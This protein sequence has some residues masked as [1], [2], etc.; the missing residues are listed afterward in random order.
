MQ[1]GD[2]VLITNTA[3]VILFVNPAFEQITGHAAADVLGRT[4][5]FLNAGVHHKFFFDT[6]WRVI[7]G[8][9]VFRGVISNRHK[10]G[11]VYQH[12][13]TITAI[14]DEADEI[15]HFLS[16]GRDV[17]ERQL[18]ATRFE[19]LA[20][21]DLLTGL[22]NRGLFMDRLAQAMLRCQREPSNLALLFID[23]DRFKRI[24]DSHGHSVGDEVLVEVARRLRSA[25]RNEDSVARLGGDEFTI[26]I[27]RLEQ[28]DG[29]NRVGQSVIAAFDAP[30]EMDGRS[31]SVGVS[32]GIAVYPGDGD[33]Q[34]TL[35]KHADI[36]MF[37]AKAAGR[38][39]YAQFGEVQK[40]AAPAPFSRADAPGGA[41]R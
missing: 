4:P 23:V 9:Q 13:Q 31:F 2:S 22:P 7:R 19:Y 33:D 32:V 11:D 39:N 25:V 28:P 26:I 38:C 24:N 10:N 37:H 17:T 27:E 5:S 29:S 18:V 8:G 30:F 1:T 6:L 21:H 14:R 3:G 20:S 15:T 35:L 12:E 16:T 34:G 41:G 40:N 36:A